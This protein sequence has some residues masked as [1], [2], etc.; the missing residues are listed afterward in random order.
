MESYWYN[1]EILVLVIFQSA[2]TV[3]MYVCIFSTNHNIKKWSTRKIYVHWKKNTTSIAFTM[4]V[5]TY[6]TVV[7]PG[8]DHQKMIL[9]SVEKDNSYLSNLYD[10]LLRIHYLL[11]SKIN[12]D[13]RS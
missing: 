7:V 9:D 4:Y 1:R 13:V 5:R 2:D 10:F 11:K 12:Y 6:C 8:K 3:Y